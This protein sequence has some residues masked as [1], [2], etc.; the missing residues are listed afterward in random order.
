MEALL[1]PDTSA[2][3]ITAGNLMTA[4]PDARIGLRASL[5]I[6][7]ADITRYNCAT[8]PYANAT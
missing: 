3:A 8:L 7:K 1:T 5:T 6:K 2:Q 4:H